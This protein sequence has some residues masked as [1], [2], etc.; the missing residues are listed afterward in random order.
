MQHFRFGDHGPFQGKHATLKRPREITEFSFDESHVLHTLDSRSL[1]YYY[2]PFFKTPHNPHEPGISLSKGF[3]SFKRHEEQEDTHL[4]PLIE[5]VIQYE[6]KT[7]T[8]LDPT[9]LTWRGMMT[10][11]LSAPFDRFGEFKMNAT[12][13]DGT[14]YIEENFA[15]KMAEGDLAKRDFNY[16]GKTQEEMTYWG[17]KFETLSTI[18]RAWDDCSRDEIENRE[19]D[20]VSNHAQYCSVVRTGVGKHNIIIGGEVDAVMGC[21][22]DHPADQIPY[23]ELKTSED[24]SPD[25]RKSAVKFERKMCRFWAQSYLLGVPTIVVGFR[26]KNGILQRIE[27]WN[28]LDIPKMV[29]QNGQ[30]WNAWVCL[31][32]ASQFLDFL[33]EH[34]TSDGCW[35]VERRKGNAE[36]TMYRINDEYS[37]DI[38]P[39]KFRKHREEFSFEKSIFDET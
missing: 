14:I 19:S 6:E 24:F 27:E 16:H 26:S 33:K 12:Y 21:K 17:Y 29:N 30:T 1:R 22:P 7:K 39:P 13:F 9:I 3:Q 35:T 37:R 4:N 25:D 5:T 11:I 8:K 34:V 15:A 20:V 10:K 36:I 28:T 31:N 23:V 38:V 18:P 2:P 32:F